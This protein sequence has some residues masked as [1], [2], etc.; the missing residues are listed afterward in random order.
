MRSVRL[1]GHRVFLRMWPGALQQEVRAQS[2]DPERDPQG[3]E[4]KILEQGVAYRSIREL[5]IISC[6]YSLNEAPV[7]RFVL[8]V[9]V[10]IRTTPD[11]LQVYK[12][13]LAEFVNRFPVRGAA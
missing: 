6:G 10:C 3:L 12:K 13:C 7:Y 11:T 5:S 2:G 8:S 4:R 1:A 9:L